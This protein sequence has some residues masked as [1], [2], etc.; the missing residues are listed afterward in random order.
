[1]LSITVIIGAGMGLGIRWY[2]AKRVAADTLNVLNWM[3]GIA[4]VLL[5]IALVM[6]G[7]LLIK[8]RGQ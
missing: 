3:M 1:M 7:I 2:G 5:V 6:L 4:S 8:G